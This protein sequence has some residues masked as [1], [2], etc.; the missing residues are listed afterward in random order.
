MTP[1]QRTESLTK[2][3]PERLLSLVDDAAQA[4]IVLPEFQRSF[5]WTRED[6]EELLVSILQGYFIGTFLILDTSPQCALFP[7]RTIEGLEY[8][9]KD[10]KPENHGTIRL[11]L[12]GQQRLTS[13]FY[14][15]YEPQIPLRNSQNPYR[16]FLRLDRIIDGNV[17]DS[18]CGISRAETRRISEMEQLFSESKAVPLRLFRDPSRFYPWLHQEQ[19]ALSEDEKQIVQSFHEVFR[20]FMVPV[21]SISPDIGKENIVNIFE[22]INRTGMPLS[23]F[24]LA[25]ARL[26]TKGINLQKL[27]KD[28]KHDNKILAEVIKPEMILKLISIW[29]GKEPR[30]GSLLDTIDAMDKARFEQQWKEAC[31]W[32]HKAYERMTCWYGAFEPR[33]IP[34]STLL[35]PLAALLCFVTKQRGGE[36][37]YRKIDSWYWASVF[38]QRYDQAVDTT[39]IRDFRE[40]T[41]WLTNDTCPSWIENFRADQID[42][43]EVKETR[44]AIYRGV[45]CLIVQSGAKDFI[46]GQPASLSDCQDDHIFP[47]ASYRQEPHVDS[48]LNRTLI[49]ISS[50]KIKSKKRPSEYLQEFLDKHGEDKNRFR[51][52]LDSHLISQEAQQAMENNDFN[53]FIDARKFTIQHE[54]ERRVKGE[55]QS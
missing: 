27:W 18:V 28:F 16:F 45:M 35:V 5:V 29:E 34:Y 33:W 26:Y 17:E 1:I 11:V 9:N 47:K 40:I 54:I 15:L 13:L 8:I 49:S 53:S 38:T 32:I 12:D 24:D 14:V 20:N 52:T 21:V 55:I 7:F 23:L 31:N 2:A 25:V 22:R 51:A 19:K 30:K 41:Q 39:S 43:I 37:M 42:L 4:K 3:N 48:I 46:T 44:S 50:N 10:A 6:I 36:D